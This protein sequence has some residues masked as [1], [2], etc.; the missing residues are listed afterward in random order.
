MK[1]I[2][3]QIL[4]HVFVINEICKQDKDPVKIFTVSCKDKT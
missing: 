3:G 4:F 1:T 2:C